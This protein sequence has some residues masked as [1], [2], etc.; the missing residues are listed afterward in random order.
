MNNGNYRKIE[1]VPCCYNCIYFVDFDE[2]DPYC[3]HPKMD[4]KIVEP[5]GIC[6]YFDGE[7]RG[8]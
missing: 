3:C 4:Q 8:N 7:I 5:I 2:D 6:N 1:Y